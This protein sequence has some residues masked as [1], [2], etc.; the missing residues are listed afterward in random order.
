MVTPPINSPRA[1]SS[2]GEQLA[3]AGTAIILFVLVV[4]CTVSVDQLPGWSGNPLEV[5]SPITG[6]T[7]AFDLLFDLLAVAASCLALAGAALR[8]WTARWW[9]VGCLLAGAS[10]VAYHCFQPRHATLDQILLGCRWLA[11]MTAAFA[12]WHA[13]RIPRV[14]RMVIAVSLSLLVT[15]ALRG[16]YQVWVEHPQLLHTF[17]MDKSRILAA[18]GWSEGSAMALSYERRISQAEATGWFGLSNVFATLMAAG[19]IGLTGL[20]LG[21]WNTLQT[22]R[23]VFATL[24]SAALL[25]LG[26]VYLTHSK[27]GAAAVAAGALLLGVFEV[28]RRRRSLRRVLPFVCLG[29]V[30][31]ALAAI[32]VRGFI[33]ERIGELSL[34]FRWFYLVGASRII[35]EHPFVGVGP[36]GFK[37]AYMIFKPAISPE[38]VSSPHSLF[39]DWTAA[40]G[41]AGVL[42]SV[43]VVR[44]LWNAAQS[45]HSAPTDTNPDSNNDDAIIPFRDEARSMF[46]IFVA[47]TAASALFEHRIATIDITLL[48]LAALAGSTAVAAAVSASLRTPSSSITPQWWGRWAIVAAA[49]AALTHAQIELTGVTAGASMWL[50]LLLA[51]AAAGAFTGPAPE[52]TPSRL[53]HMSWAAVALIL[54]IPAVLLPSVVTWERAL[55]SAAHAVEDVPLFAERLAA[56][57]NRRPLYQDSRAT[58]AVDLGTALRTTVPENNESLQAAINRLRVTASA[59]A[60]AQLNEAI[61]HGPPSFDIARA[62]SHLKLQLATERASVADWDAARRL[63]K[64]AYAAIQANR[65]PE[66]ASMFAWL[67]TSSRASGDLFSDA[68]D[69]DMAANW[70]E[71]ATSYAPYEPQYRVE[72]ARLRHR[73]GQRQLAQAAARE[74]LRLS[75]NLYLDP[76]RQLSAAEQAEMR[77]IANPSPASPTPTTP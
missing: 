9:H 75:D 3:I 47:A 19:A 8:A 4:R 37:D 59:A 69:L 48:R 53:A 63:S 2:R 33:G 66:S 52:R 34:L 44:Q 65:G 57:N 45:C 56:I 6:I 38:D 50:L 54:L 30:A 13:A 70:F 72:I 36:A 27:G 7:P 32:V 71:S 26:G 12:I 58:L 43:L 64:E 14:R 22:R 60:A 51:A 55:R 42:W 77:Q 31:S 68:F 5:E 11:A 41:V 17:N 10:M 67:G 46:L 76:L 1:A 73:A 61:T 62:V 35:T 29:L 18:Q 24:A 40:L 74:A 28:A 23:W 49:V 20:A 21:A 16:G 25:C 39:I 15:L